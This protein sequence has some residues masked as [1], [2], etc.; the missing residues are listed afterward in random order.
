[1]ASRDYTERSVDLFIFSGAAEQGRNR[2]TPS[3]GLEHGGQVTTGIQKVAQ[4]FVVRFL[5]RKGSRP[6]NPRF[7]TGFIPGILTAN[8]TDADM[9][10][11]F[12]EAV[13]DLLEQSRAEAARPA[14][15][16]DETLVNAEL[17][18]Y[19]VPAEDQLLLTIQLQTAAGEQRTVI[20]PVSLAIR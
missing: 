15:P 3:L 19:A 10:V 12:R 18:A 6:F 1:M 4:T 9:A 13:D 20:L 5:T 7:G 2:I 11:L 16:A 17:L 14:A 8:L